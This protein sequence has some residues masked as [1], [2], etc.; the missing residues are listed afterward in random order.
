[1]DWPVDAWKPSHCKLQWPLVP[2]YM[3]LPWSHCIASMKNSGSGSEERGKNSHQLQRG[4]WV[5]D[6]QRQDAWAGRGLASVTFNGWP[7]LCR[8]RF[9]LQELREAILKYQEPDSDLFPSVTCCNRPTVVWR[10]RYGAWAIVSRR[11]VSQAATSPPHSQ[12]FSLFLKAP[13]KGGRLNISQGLD[14]C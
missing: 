14:S 11:F 10:V 2:F 8:W 1:M 9:R 12:D 5:A 13:C 4:E 7:F 6:G 3:C